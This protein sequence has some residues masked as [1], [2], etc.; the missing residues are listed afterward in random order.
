M[1]K[2][3]P[4]AHAMRQMAARSILREAD[5]YPDGGGA[6]K[7]ATQT[8]PRHRYLWHLKLRPP[9]HQDLALG[10]SRQISEPKIG[11]GFRLSGL[12]G[13]I[14]T[15]IVGRAETAPCV[16]RS[17]SFTVILKVE[18]DN[19]T[20]DWDSLE[21]HAAGSSHSRQKSLNRSGASSV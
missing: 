18:T 9:G 12:Q 2:W 21:A 3:G 11:V 1:E 13:P 4:W 6:F 16:D 10:L 17:P 8:M 15:M 14:Q 7:G 5:C 19:E 20:V